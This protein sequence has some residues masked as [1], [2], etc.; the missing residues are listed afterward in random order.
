MVWNDLGFDEIGSKSGEKASI[1]DELRFYHQKWSDYY[2]NLT[3]Y[4]KKCG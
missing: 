4:Q 1:C 2:N 3:I